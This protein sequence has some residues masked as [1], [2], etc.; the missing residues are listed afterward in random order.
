MKCEFIA[1]HLD[2]FPISQPP[3]FCTTPT[4]AVSMP[5]M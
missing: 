5:V 4:E 1:A 3:V 2:E